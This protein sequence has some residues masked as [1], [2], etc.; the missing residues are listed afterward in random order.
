LKPYEVQLKQF[1]YGEALNSAL[2]TNHLLIVASLIEELMRRDGL[3]I[4]LKDRNEA[5]LAPLVDFI[6][7]KILNPRY[8]RLLIYVSNLILD[9]YSALLGE[10]EVLRSLFQ[11]LQ[12]RVH[13]DVRYQKKLLSIQG[14]LETIIASSQTGET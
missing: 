2:E 12:R 4:A 6:T 1:K 8:S 11:T 9:M 3:V 13:S 7:S 14:I 5:T 10:S